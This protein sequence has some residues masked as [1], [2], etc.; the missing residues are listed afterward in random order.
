MSSVLVRIER[1]G[2]W[3]VQGKSRSTPL[4]RRHGAEDSEPVLNGNG[5]HGVGKEQMV[6]SGGEVR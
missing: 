6:V 2:R 3:R 1:E 5:E 4:C